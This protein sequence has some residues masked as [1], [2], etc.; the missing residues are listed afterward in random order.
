MRCHGQARPGCPV[1]YRASLSVHRCGA[2]AGSVSRGCARLNLPAVCAAQSNPMVYGR[3]GR[4]KAG[5]MLLCGSN[6]R[7]K[8]RSRTQYAFLRALQCLQGIRRSPDTQNTFRSRM[9]SARRF[10]GL[11]GICPFLLTSTARLKRCCWTTFIGLGSR[12]ADATTPPA[13]C[14]PVGVGINRVQPFPASVPATG[15]TVDTSLP[16]IRSTRPCDVDS[17]AFSAS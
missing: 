14:R 17:R 5:L 8:W 9:A 7:G 6:T 15:A 10:T 4:G 12:H 3:R 16:S 13:S 2:V 11:S 1:G